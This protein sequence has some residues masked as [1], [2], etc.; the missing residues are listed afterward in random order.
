MFFPLLA[1]L[2][3]TGTSVE[4]FAP[5]ANPSFTRRSRSNSNSNT[6]L[7]FVRTDETLEARLRTVQANWEGIKSSVSK[8]L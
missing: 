3:L 1:V 2:S 7:N 6:K 5:N 8:N 4:S